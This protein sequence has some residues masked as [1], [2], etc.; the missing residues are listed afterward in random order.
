M[1]T[2]FCRFNSFRSI[3][4]ASTSRATTRTRSTH[5]ARGRGGRG[6]RGLFENLRDEIANGQL[7]T[8]NYMSLVYMFWS[9]MYT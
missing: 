7:K 5:G 6:R 3:L 9:Y 4:V 1:V 2:I 8:V